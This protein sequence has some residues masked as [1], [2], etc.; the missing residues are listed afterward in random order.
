M[1]PSARPPSRFAL[2]PGRAGAKLAA[3]ALLLVLPLAVPLGG[4]RR[5]A[6]GPTEPGPQ[7][8][9]PPP[10]AQTVFDI[11]LTRGPPPPSAFPGVDV[12]VSGGRFE[13][14]WRVEQPTDQMVIDSGRFVKAGYLEATFTMKGEPWSLNDKVDWIGVFENP[15]LDQRIG[16]D[17]FFLR[18]GMTKYGFSM[19]KA[20]GKA[21]DQTE[22]FRIPKG[23]EQARGLA[24]WVID[25]SR[26][27]KVK[28]EWRD[29][30][31]IAHLADGRVHR[32]PEAKCN[33]GMPIDR[34]RYVALGKDG[35]SERALVGIRFRRV[36]LA[37]YASQP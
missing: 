20:Y 3:A 10:P 27:M 7:A 13:D 32:C 15:Q 6:T 19:P 35:Y 2:A 12:K 33:A 34:L 25:D 36:R 37:E 29:G 24:S 31:A 22:W 9:A 8:D 21:V 28:L 4:C 16:P 23:D 30:V 1:S 5:P 11:D 18:T 17:L 14:G 26:E